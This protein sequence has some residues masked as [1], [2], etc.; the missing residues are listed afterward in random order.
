MNVL[1]K[2]VSCFRIQHEALERLKAI[3]PKPRASAVKLYSWLA[4]KGIHVHEDVAEQVRE[5]EYPGYMLVRSVRRQGHFR[6]KKDEVFL[7]EVLWGERV[8]LLPEDDRWFTVYFAQH[9]IAL[10]DS[11][12]LRVAPL[13]TNASP[14]V[15]PDQKVSDMRPV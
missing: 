4:F 2:H 5:P 10:F 15:E 8:G 13:L 1:G 12:Q 7:S 3:N 11:Q 6:W 9:P 14:L